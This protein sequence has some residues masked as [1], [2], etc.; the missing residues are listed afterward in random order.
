MSERQIWILAFIALLV[1]TFMTVFSINVTY[2]EGTRTVLKIFYVFFIVCLIPTAYN[3]AKK[4]RA[5][6]RGEVV[7]E[8]KK[9]ILPLWLRFFVAIVL[10][11]IVLGFMLGIIFWFAG[12]PSLGEATNKGLSILFFA[13]SVLGVILFIFMK[14][15]ARVEERWGI[16][17]ERGLPLPPPPQ[18]R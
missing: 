10:S 6:A 18:G 4:A 12:L 2:D 15:V 9:I 14:Y 11:M 8:E 1:M 17:V 7:V 16:E 3:S 13:I 5:R